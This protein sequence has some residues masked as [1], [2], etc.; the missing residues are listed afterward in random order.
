MCNNALLYLH[1]VN[2]SYLAYTIHMHCPRSVKQNSHE[3]MEAEQ[4]KIS[5]LRERGG[6]APIHSN[7]HTGPTFSIFEDS[8]SQT[9][10]DG[11]VYAASSAAFFNLYSRYPIGGKDES[12]ACNIL[13]NSRYCE[14]LNCDGL[15]R[16][17]NRFQCS[18]F[19]FLIGKCTKHFARDI[20]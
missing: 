9:A 8:M 2:Y 18:F 13:L 17:D 1:R 11:S 7:G 4:Q 6:G 3:Q 15:V 10:D 16:N 14:S 19:F 5:L 20:I 12:G